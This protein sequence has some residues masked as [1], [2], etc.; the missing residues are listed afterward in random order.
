MDLGHLDEISVDGARMAATLPSSF[1]WR[2]QGKVTSVKNQNPC[3]TCWVHGTLAATESRVLIK[4]GTSYD[5]SEQNLNC[6]TDPAWAYLI[7][8]RCNGGG[9]SS[10]A[11]DTLTKKGTRLET[12]QPYNTSTINSEACNDSCQSIKLVTDYRVIAE[13]ATT[14]ATIE[15]IKNAIYNHGPL[16]MSYAADDGSHMYTGSVYYWPNCPQ[17]EVNHLVCIIGWDD[18]IV[19]PAGGGSGAWIVKNSWGPGW[20]IDGFFYLCYGSAGMCEVTSLDYKDYDTNEQ[21]YYWDEAGQIG[22]LGNW[23]DCSGWMA[24]IFASNQDGNLTHVDF[25]TTSNNAQYEIYVYLDGDISD[26]LQNQAASQMGTCQEFGYYSIPLTSPVSLVSGQSFTI[27]VKMTTLGYKYPLSVEYQVAQGG[28]TM[29]DPPIQNGK[30]FFRHREGESW[31]D[32]ATQECNACLRGRITTGGT[33][34]QPDITVTPPNFDVTLAQGTSQ[35]Y[36]MTI[37][38]AGDATL[39][40]TISDRDATGQTSPA[41]VGSPTLA[42]SQITVHL[43]ELSPSQPMSFATPPTTGTEIAYDDGVA[44]DAWCWYEADFLDAVRFTPPQYPVDLKVARLC[45]APSWPDAD[46]EQFA[47]EIYDDDGAGGAPGT[48]LG[49]ITATANDWGWYDVDI[50]S[51]GITIASGDFYTAYRQFSEAPD[52]EALCV[53]C[54]TPNGRSWV[55]AEGE[56]CSVEL[57]VEQLDWMIRCVVDAGAAKTL[58]SIAA[59]P[60]PVNLSVGENQQLTISA[61]YSDSSTADVTSASTYLSS[62]TS[63]ATVTTAGLIQALSQASAVITVSY[64]EGGITKITNVPV[65]VTAWQDC[66]WLD[67]NPKLGSVPPGTPRNMTITVNTAGL[68]V[69]DYYADIVIANNDPDENPTIVPV[70]LHVA[71]GGNYP[72]TSPSDPSPANHAT[73]VSINADLSWMGGDPDVGD[74]VTYDVYFGSNATPPLVSN[75]QPGTTY[76]PGVL[77]YNTQ[78]Y[79]KIV[80]TDNHGAST[81]GPLWD[82]TTGAEPGPGIIWIFPYGVEAFLCPTPANSRPYLN[83]A[84]ALPTGT[85][86]A[87]LLGVYWLDE[88]VGEWK[89]FKPGFALNTLNFLE[90]G[91]AYLV[92]V[93]GACSWTIS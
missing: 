90:P 25:W 86:P 9:F 69:G 70:T 47:V 77:S 84:V 17:N 42:P 76:D 56:W 41:E 27:A 46:H 12:C 2:D 13:K 52:C 83:A 35:D 30:T 21:L 31:T 20:G 22:G 61:T 58:Q 66:S 3:G 37:G 73:A 14:P 55:G 8:N 24:S 74:M 10:L 45:F 63:V 38:N 88:S 48:L 57:I 33:T 36:T 62:N 51:L 60:T 91:Q 53:D 54:S 1:D 67:E 78:Y 6:C 82:F 11:A 89:Y 71:S 5:F 79:W 85:E 19:H 92:A 7:G 75:E 65:T 50:S 15:P 4:E 28:K 23:E 81:M 18:S 40:Y 64:S 26:G 39:T 59:L 44:E 93:S 32:T 16:T 49:S 29:V 68:A 72:P 80:A 87:E 34:G 43:M